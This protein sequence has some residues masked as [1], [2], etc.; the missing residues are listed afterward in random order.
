MNPS[1]WR[2]TDI[3]LVRHSESTNNC[4]YELVQER[5]SELS[6][7]RMDEEVD[8]LHDPDCALSPRGQRQAL[9]LREH[10]LKHPLTPNSSSQQGTA[11]RILSSPM[12]RCL[13]TAQ[14][15]AIGLG[16]LLVTVHPQLFESDGCY[17][18]QPDGTTVGLPGMTAA[19]VETSFPSFKC[20]PGMEAG[21]YH[22]PRKESAEEFMVRAK[23]LADHLWALHDKEEGPIVLVAHGNVMRELIS[24]MLGTSGMVTHCNT[25]VSHL[26]LW[27]SEQEGRRLATLQYA[28][29]VDHLLSQPEIIS[30][31]EVFDDHWIQEY[32]LHV[33]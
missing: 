15:V 19:E 5:F 11:F 28:N 30:G 31:N 10:L 22:L 33:P 7:E 2:R 4:L 6:P 9:L 23:G 24:R 32:V 21:W 12:K 26:Q 8:K 14:Q 13:L 27:S 1:S 18:P 25:G 17:Q 16:G 3:F 20:L 29:R